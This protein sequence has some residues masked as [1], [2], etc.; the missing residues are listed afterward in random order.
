VFSN[1]AA[2]L[3]HDLAAKPDKATRTRTTVSENRDHQTIIKHFSPLKSRERSLNEQFLQQ[4]RKAML[5]GMA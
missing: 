3:L 2:F 5:P 1:S 4:K